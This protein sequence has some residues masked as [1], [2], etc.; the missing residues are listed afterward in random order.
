MRTLLFFLFSAMLLV[1]GGTLLAGETEKIIEFNITGTQ[2]NHAPKTYEVQLSDPVNGVIS[3]GGATLTIQSGSNAQT[4]TLTIRMLDSVVD[5]NGTSGTT[6]RFA[7]DRSGDTSSAVSVTYRVSGTGDT[8]A[9]ASDFVGNIL[10]SAAVGFA[11]GET[12]KT[13]T[14]SIAGKAAPSSTV[15]YQVALS[16]PSGANLGTPSTVTAQIQNSGTSI[17]TIWSISS[18][19]VTVD[20]GEN[21]TTQSVDITRNNGTGS[22]S[23]TYTAAAGGQV[24]AEAG[25]FVPAGFPT[26]TASFSNLETIKRL[27][28]NIAGK[29]GTGPTV[30][31]DVALSNP[32]T[33]EIGTGS[34]R[35]T[36]TDSGPSATVKLPL[37][38]HSGSTT[39]FADGQNNQWGADAHFVGGTAIATASAIAG[40]TD[41]GLYA[42]QRTGGPV[43]YLFAGV[44]TGQVYD[45]T[46]LFA[47][48]DSALSGTCSV[49][50]DGPRKMDVYS[51]SVEL[52]AD[53]DPC[54][55]VGH[56]AAHSE[57]IANVSADANGEIRLEVRAN[58]AATH[59]PAVAGIYL[60][61]RE[62]P[63]TPERFLTFGQ[64]GKTYIDQVGKEWTNG[65]QF[66]LGCNSVNDGEVAIVGTDNPELFWG[67][68]EGPVLN[69]NIPIDITGGDTRTLL[70]GFS[71]HTSTASGQRA[72]TVVA[73]GVTV[74]TGFDIVAASGAPD[75]AH[76]LRQDVT[77]A[78][79]VINITIT[80]TTGL[81]QLN[82]IAVMNPT[83]V[84]VLPYVA[85]T[86]WKSEFLMPV[87]AIVQ[88]FAPPRGI[89]ASGNPLV[90]RALDDTASTMFVNYAPCPASPMHGL[91][92]DT[93]E[94][95][96]NFFL[97]V[98]TW[99]PAN[100]DESLF[101]LE[102]NESVI[103]T[104][105]VEVCELNRMTGETTNCQ[106]FSVGVRV[107]RAGE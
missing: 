21:G 107:S 72:M 36:V 12:S 9:A 53:I 67:R 58:T 86:G 7:V 26:A 63:P 19:T 25:D 5:R 33:G 70:L 81:A 17:A 68:C 100:H 98:Q 32:S 50:V 82:N 88:A 38:I 51:N 92:E 104:F 85:I 23:I 3:G 65:D 27:T 106:P 56:L 52:V 41:D 42:K 61:V 73:E 14:L 13:V 83:E 74:A 59:L 95:K 34:V 66:V 89:A 69:I 31:Y 71:D 49:G 48:I 18:P 11:A 79:G 40:T 45:L 87:N 84:P 75:H 103:D 94:T 46:L 30:A 55:E 20:R 76:K 96:Q 44:P 8:P 15:S 37:R 105:E 97:C 47:E 80:G 99:N 4:P 90:V 35:L 43:K 78:D 64:P 22:A 24:P 102:L 2:T 57:T 62:E 77:A 60:R 54:K 29:P 91:K 39:L 16:N 28:W 101:D 10:P 93:P 1:A 6:Q